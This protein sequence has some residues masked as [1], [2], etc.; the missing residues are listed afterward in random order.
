MKNVIR[1]ISCVL[2]TVVLTGVGI[3]AFVALMKIA[4]A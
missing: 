1:Q 3:L 2:L 4:T